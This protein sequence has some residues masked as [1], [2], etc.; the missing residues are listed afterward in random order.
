MSRTIKLQIARILACGGD[1]HDRNNKT[2]LVKVYVVDRVES[3][4]CL[5]EY[6]RGSREP[7]MIRPLLHGVESQR[8][9]PFLHVSI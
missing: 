6:Y 9:D 3:R 7:M 2:C 4:V 5:V 1:R 8:T